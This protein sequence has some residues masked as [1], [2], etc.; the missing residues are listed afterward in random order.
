[1]KKKQEQYFSKKSLEI[2]FQE[3]NIKLSDILRNL[4]KLFSEYESHYR[5]YINSL[6]PEKN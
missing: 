2:T 3:K 5:A 1:M 6:E 4:E